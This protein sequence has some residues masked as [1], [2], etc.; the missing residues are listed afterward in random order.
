M[1]DNPNIIPRE[2]KIGDTVRWVTDDPDSCWYGCFGTVTEVRPNEWSS[3]GKPLYRVGPFP[4]NDHW[5]DTSFD[6]VAIASDRDVE[7]FDG[8]LPPFVAHEPVVVTPSHYA[9]FRR[10][11]IVRIRHTYKSREIAG[12]FGIVVYRSY[13]PDHLVLSPANVG[14]LYSHWTETLGDVDVSVPVEHCALHSPG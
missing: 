10:G 12:S 7:Y 1:T 6:M 14:I 2:L 3:A 9:G 8:K 13:D 11:S 5:P 4:N